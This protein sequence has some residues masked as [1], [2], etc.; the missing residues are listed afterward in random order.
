MRVAMPQS[1]RAA[2]AKLAEEA[3]A[4]AKV[5]VAAAIELDF[6]NAGDDLIG[7][8]VDPGVPQ[9]AGLGEGAAD[10]RQ[11]SSSSSGG[12]SGGSC[13]YLELSALQRALEQP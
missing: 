9:L 7:T 12:G 8:A 13:Q 1:S 3:A 4:A 2:Q 6:D 11:L 5:A 10:C